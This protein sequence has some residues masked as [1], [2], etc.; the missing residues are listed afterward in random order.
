MC[1]ACKEH[2][3]KHEL[4]KITRTNDGTFSLDQRAQGRGAYVCIE[5]SCIDK[6]ISRKLLHKAFKTKI[7]DT[8]YESLYKEYIG[9][10]DKN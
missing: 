4:L 6:C 2:K 5:H 8:T 3:P 7:A 1:I 10:T 9:H